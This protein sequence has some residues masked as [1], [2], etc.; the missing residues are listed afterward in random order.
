MC[1]FPYEIGDMV[2]LGRRSFIIKGYSSYYGYDSNGAGARIEPKLS[3]PYLDGVMQKAGYA[4]DAE[5][6]LIMKG[7]AKII[8]GVENVTSKEI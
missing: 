1:K 5:K 7:F 8:K 6:E 2:E 3:R 4:L